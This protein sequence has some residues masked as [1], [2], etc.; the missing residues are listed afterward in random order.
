MSRS[1]KKNPIVK[2]G[3][4][5]KSFAK[6]L[7]N[8]KVRR[9]KGISVGCQYKKIFCSWDICDNWDRTT[10]NEH[11]EFRTRIL[12]MNISNEDYLNINKYVNNWKKWYLRK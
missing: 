10:L 4:S 5:R 8:K 9:Y 2:D 7:S 12:S 11:L 6:R 3:N 1:Y